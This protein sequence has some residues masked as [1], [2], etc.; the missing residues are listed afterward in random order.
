M[1]CVH[2]V[3]TDMAGLIR[4]RRSS[5]FTSRASSMSVAAMFLPRRWPCTDAGDGGSLLTPGNRGF[6]TTRR[7]PCAQSPSMKCQTLC[8]AKHCVVPKQLT[9]VHSGPWNQINLDSTGLNEQESI[10][11]LWQNGGNAKG[12]GMLRSRVDSG[13]GLAL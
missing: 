9:L 11:A 6:D 3:H 13:E 2:R 7:Q 5:D 8:C 4:W 10:A 1:R 12:T